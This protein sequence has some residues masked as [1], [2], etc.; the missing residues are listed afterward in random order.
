[1]KLVLETIAG[2]A[3][4]AP[5]GIPAL[6]HEVGNDAVENRPVVERDAG[7][8]LARPRVHPFLGARSEAYEVLHRLGRPFLLEAENDAS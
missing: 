4:A 6:N 1:M 5:D 7:S 2:A 3:R 8:G